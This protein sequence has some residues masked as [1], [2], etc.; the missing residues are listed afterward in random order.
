MFWSNAFELRRKFLLIR[1]CQRGMIAVEKHL[2]NALQPFTDC[3]LRAIKFS[4][5]TLYFALVDLQQRMKKAQHK[6]TWEN[7]NL[8]DQRSADTARGHRLSP[9]H[10]G[11]IHRR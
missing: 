7:N 6:E 11:Q 2:T 9:R 1:L 4:A 10:G 3:R 8:L 5:I